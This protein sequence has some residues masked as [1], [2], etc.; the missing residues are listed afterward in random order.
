MPT[1]M[2]TQLN[3][4]AA[5]IFSMPYSGGAQLIKLDITKASDEEIVNEIYCNLQAVNSLSDEY[6]RRDAEELQRLRNIELDVIAL[7]RILG[8]PLDK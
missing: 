6:R 4:L 1:Q 3:K 2:R 5:M 8:T 7:R